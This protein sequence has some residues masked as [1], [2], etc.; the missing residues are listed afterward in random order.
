M[1]IINLTRAIAENYFFMKGLTKH[2]GEPIHLSETE[3]E[4]V[5]AD[6]RNDRFMLHRFSFVFNIKSVKL[7]HHN[8]VGKF[9][10]KENIGLE[11]FFFKVHPDYMADYLRWGEAIY[12]YAQELKAKIQPLLQT[13]RIT[14]PIKLKDGKYH[15]VLQ[16]SMAFQL[17][18]EKNM[19][20]HLNI[21]SVAR[22]FDAKEKI[23]LIGDL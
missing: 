5:L 9:M 22:P 8:N 10:S 4:K 20:S 15:W 7:T 11:E 12:S 2:F 1:D 21:Y 18:S 3:C 23:P 6:L 14:I 13:Y 19:V 16:E 17:D